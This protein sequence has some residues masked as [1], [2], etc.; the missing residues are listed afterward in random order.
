MYRPSPEVYQY[1]INNL[2]FKES[3]KLFKSPS[4]ILDSILKLNG[5]DNDLNETERREMAKL[6]RSVLS[7]SKGPFI[8]DKEVSFNKSARKICIGIISDKLLNE[9]SKTQ[10]PIQVPLSEV[11]LA[12][13]KQAKTELTVASRLSDPQARRTIKQ[14]GFGLSAL[15]D[16]SFSNKLTEA[17]L[18]AKLTETSLYIQVKFWVN[19]FSIARNR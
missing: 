11:R 17:E 19:L 9:M 1:C 8:L 15:N 10:E 18:R 7:K 3:V 12:R 4:P 2:E 14:A 16:D 6:R 5:G 13:D